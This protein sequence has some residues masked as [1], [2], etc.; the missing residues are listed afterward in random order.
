ML[1]GDMLVDTNYMSTSGYEIGSRSSRVW[2]SQAQQQEHY[3]GPLLNETMEE[4][5][6]KLSLNTLRTVF[7]ERDKA[8]RTSC[9]DDF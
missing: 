2:A 6:G 3:S 9:E 4:F 7:W 1:E 8:R 5:S